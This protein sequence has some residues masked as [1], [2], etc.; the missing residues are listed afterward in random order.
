MPKIVEP[1]T[2]QA[3]PLHYPS[4]IMGDGARVKRLPTIEDLS[5]GN[6]CS[7]HL[8]YRGPGSHDYITVFLVSHAGGC[9]TGVQD[10]AGTGLLTSGEQAWYGNRR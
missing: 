6:R 7:I 5:L 2:L 9:Y 4:K 10:T 8:S 3:R 1:D